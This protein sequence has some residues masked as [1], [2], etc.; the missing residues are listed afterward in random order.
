MRSFRPSC[1]RGRCGATARAAQACE[2]PRWHYSTSLSRRRTF[3]ATS[4]LR[5]IAP[6]SSSRHPAC[7][8]LSHRCSTATPTS[9]RWDVTDRMAARPYL[10][11]GDGQSSRWCWV[12]TTRNRA[13]ATLLLI[14]P[15]PH[16]SFT[17]NDNVRAHC[18]Y[19]FLML[20]PRFVFFCMAQGS[21]PA[22]SRQNTLMHSNT[23]VRIFSM[24]SPAVWF[25]ISHCPAFR[26]EMNLLILSQLMTVILMSS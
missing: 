13:Y 17:W 16:K 5:A 11:R 4:R 19:L 23:Y 2:E 6:L 22:L 26:F 25:A 20:F 14:F 21:R 7:R 9:G 12:D 24:A 10:T 8:A 15:M 18:A 1:P 3:Q